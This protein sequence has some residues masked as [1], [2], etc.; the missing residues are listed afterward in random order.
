LAGGRRCLGTGSRIIFLGPKVVWI[1]RRG[2]HQ[3]SIQL[4][5]LV[6]IVLIIVVFLLLI[7]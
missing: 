6:W 2:A 4:K 5:I 7:F 3:V 1:L